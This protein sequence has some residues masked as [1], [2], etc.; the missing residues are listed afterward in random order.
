M[1]NQIPGNS[2]NQDPNKPSPLDP[3]KGQEDRPEWQPDPSKKDRIVTNEQR[4]V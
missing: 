3:K 1:E 4:P 2:E